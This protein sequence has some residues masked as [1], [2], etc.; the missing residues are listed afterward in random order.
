MILAFIGTFAGNGDAVYADESTHHVPSGGRDR[1]VIEPSGRNA[2]PLYKSINLYSPLRQPPDR[3]VSA[4]IS[5]SLTIS[6]PFPGLSGTSPG[7]KN[8]AA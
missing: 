6:A 1:T 8:A 3:A 2:I 5:A 7:Q 4:G